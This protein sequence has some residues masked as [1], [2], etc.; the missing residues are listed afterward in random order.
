[1]YTID[2]MKMSKLILECK[3]HFL[4]INDL[5]EMHDCQ[6]VQNETMIETYFKLYLF[7]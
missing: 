3:E 7:R 1:M 2:A 6:V 4:S 5:I